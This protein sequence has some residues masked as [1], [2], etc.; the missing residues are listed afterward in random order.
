MSTGSSQ[1]ATIISIFDLSVIVGY[2]VSE[3]QGHL[4]KRRA[5]FA[6]ISFEG[7]EIPFDNILDRR[8]RFG[9]QRDALH[10]RSAC[11]VS[12]L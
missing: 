9:S 8:Y 10:T 7:A 2:L 12:E 5:S 3:S 4:K 6:P 11:E 1:H